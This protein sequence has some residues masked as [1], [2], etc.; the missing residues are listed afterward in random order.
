MKKIIYVAGGCFWGVERFYQLAF[1]NIKTKVGYLNSLIDNPTYSQVCSKVTN[2]VE[3]VEIEYD[4]SQISLKEIFDVLFLIIDP[5]SLNKQG[6][7]CGTQYRTGIYSTDI[8]DIQEAKKYIESV[9]KNYDK[10]IVVETLIL[11]NFYDAEEYHQ[12]Y[13]IK[14]PNG[15]C[16]IDMD[17]VKKIKNNY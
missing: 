13:L 5:T 1:K 17:L 3:A 14:N 16:H 6:N 9:S 11:Q 15:Y 8:N 4:D 10:P 12:N 7:D 2:A